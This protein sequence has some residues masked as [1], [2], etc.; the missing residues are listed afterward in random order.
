MELLRIQSAENTYTEGII[1]LY[2]E[3]FPVE[4]RRSPAALKQLM[5]CNSKF[6]CNAVL[7]NSELIGFFNYWN[8]ED[9]FFV[10]H[11]AIEPPLRGHKLGEKMISLARASADVPLVLEAETVEYSDWSSRRIEFY[12]RLGFE[13]VPQPYAQ[14]PYEA[15]GEYITLHLMSDAPAF[16]A[17]HFDRIKKTIYSE[18]YGV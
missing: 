6:H 12:R 16:A 10:E 1:R 18:V 7:M 8:F 4:Q 14:P 11:I 5:E 17:T 2:T 15:G 13:I 3:A 9:F